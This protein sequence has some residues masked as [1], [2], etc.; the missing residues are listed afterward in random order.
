ME[1]QV[2]MKRELFGCEISQQSKTE[3]F[4]ATELVNAGNKW[5]YANGLKNFNLS[6][7]LKS[8][9]FLEFKNEIEK[10]YGTSINSSRGRNSNTWVHP[11]LF[12]DI[13]LAI[14][15]KLKVEVYEWLFD[16]LIRFRN[17]SGDSYKEM[18]T[19]IYG[20][21]TNKR[22]FPNYIQNVATKIKLEL[23]VEDWQKAT[24]EQLKK[25]DKIHNSIKLLCNVL[26][27]TEQAVRIGIK[28][29]L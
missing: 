14:N 3:F 18:S 21:F 1:T 5:R 15:P 28:E 20:R 10:K 6:Q 4:S 9:S 27:D 24:E 25:R 29:N 26:N 11:L 17:D 22:E 23:K 19:A 13:A 8:S 12:I 2:I 7:Y 16:N